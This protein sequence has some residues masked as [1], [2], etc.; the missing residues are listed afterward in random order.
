MDMSDAIAE[1]NP[2]GSEPVLTAIV[3]PYVLLKIDPATETQTVV[4]GAFYRYHDSQDD[5]TTAQRNLSRQALQDAKFDNPDYYKTFCRLFLSKEDAR[6]Q[7]TQNW[8]DRVMEAM[9]E[10]TDLVNLVQDQAKS[11]FS[12]GKVSAHAL[13]LPSQF[14]DTESMS[15]S[16]KQKYRNEM[17]SSILRAVVGGESGNASSSSSARVRG[18]GKPK[19]GYLVPL[20]DIKARDSRLATKE[21]MSTMWEEKQAK[22]AREG[23]QVVMYTPY[24]QFPETTDEQPEQE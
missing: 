24:G 6:S 17:A 16:Q 11:A 20:D 18:A 5:T 22:Y 4:P 15:E 21:E 3:Y 2:S 19:I 1:S 13:T 7:L 12:G 23:S 9:S 14:L 10:R 8:S